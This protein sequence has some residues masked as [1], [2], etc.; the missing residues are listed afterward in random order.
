MIDIQ[1][2]SDTRDIPLEKVGVRGLEYP[3]R[4]LDKANKVQHTTAKADLLVNLPRNFKGTHMSRFIEVFHKYHTNLSH[5]NFLAMLEEI[6]EKL[7][8]ER[9]FGVLTFPFF[10]EK[11]APVSGQPGIMSYQ[12]TFEGSVSKEGS[13][14][15][16]SVALPVTTLC[17]CSKAI[18]DAGAHNQ[19]GVVKIRIRYTAFFWIEDIIALAER[20]ASSPVYSVLKREDEKFVTEQ[21]Y[22]NPRFVEDVVREVY[23]ALRS[24]RADEDTPLSF[25]SVEAENFE[26]IHNHNAYAYAEYRE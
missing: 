18:S 15:F 1:N 10:M 14:Y 11:K 7:D 22:D 9:S 13:E 16:V 5:K 24:F 26:S 23:R 20:C 25:F 8:A 17:P 3:V 6:R 2:Q 12:C 21:A 4:V 19:R